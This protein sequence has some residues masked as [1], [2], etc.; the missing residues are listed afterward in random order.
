LLQEKLVRK[1]FDIEHEAQGV[2]KAIFLE[3][4]AVVRNKTIQIR[5]H[6]AGK[7]TTAVPKRGTYGPLISAISVKSGNHFL[8]YENLFTIQLLPYLL[9]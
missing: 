3:F 8:D 4:K 9:Y 2:D 1:D 5:F 6:W 7:G